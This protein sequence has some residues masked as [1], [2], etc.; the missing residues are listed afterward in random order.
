MARRVGSRARFAKSGDGATEP[1][2]GLAS[3]SLPEALA[4]AAPALRRVALKLCDSPAEAD[5]LVQ[6]T[7]ERALRKTDRFDGRN[8][9]AWMVAIMRNLFI[10][11]CRAEARRPGIE[12]LESV[13]IAAPAPEVTPAWARLGD[14]ELRE[15]V[16]ALPARYRDVYRLRAFEKL[17]YA[18]I[19]ERL[20][21][22]IDT[23]A[24]RLSRGR[25]KLRMLLAEI[26]V[27]G[28]EGSG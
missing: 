15:A 9:A 7:F 14:A 6:D 4:A 3:A 13:A 17:S 23:V 21:I 10:D 26:A 11:R 24:S 1:A 18:A 25:H 16:E 2:G 20:E 28:K 22:P 27:Q 8:P 19:A 5:D 12:P